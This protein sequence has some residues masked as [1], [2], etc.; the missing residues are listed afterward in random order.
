MCGR[1]NIFH[2]LNNALLMTKINL[3]VPGKNYGE[4]KRYDEG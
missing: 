3:Y 4:I 1:S 2:S